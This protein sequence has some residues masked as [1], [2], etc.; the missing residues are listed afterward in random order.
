M[1][2]TKFMPQKTG[3]D[4]VINQKS[5]SVFYRKAFHS[6]CIAVFLIQLF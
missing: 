6:Y 1:Q 3:N 5:P 4:V 2:E